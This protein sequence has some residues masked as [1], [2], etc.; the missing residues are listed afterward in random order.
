LGAIIFILLPLSIVSIQLFRQLADMI[1]F[2]REYLVAYS[3]NEQDIFEDISR[4]IR[5]FTSELVIIG[6]EEIRAG[7]LAFLSSGLENLFRFSGNIVRNVGLFFAG[8]LF[9]LFVLF[10]FFLDGAYLSKMAQ[11]IIPIRKDYIQAVVGKFKEI[12]RQLIVGYV[13]VA[14][15]EAIMAFIIFSIFR[16]KASLVFSALIFFF[17]FIPVFGPAIVYMPLGILV[18]LN[19][20]LGRGILLMLVS[21]C[22]ISTIEN[23]IRPVIL[24]DR[25]QL[26]PL[27]IFFAIL[28]GIVVFGANGLIL[29]PMVIIIFL[30]VLD[31]FLR[32]HKFEEEKEIK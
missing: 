11:R 17:A 21:A 22:F 14:L 7:I 30:T 6:S 28:G 16:I 24:R 1:V 8:L 26:H 29:G 9:M 19:G 32:E 15:M 23:F 18:I 13:L 5:D 27:I 10:F 31:L 20:D 3:Q 4:F 12:S 25:I 2:L